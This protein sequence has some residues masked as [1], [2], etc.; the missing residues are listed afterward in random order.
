MPDFVPGF[1]SPTSMVIINGNVCIAF[2]VFFLEITL[3]PQ[4]PIRGTEASE[5]E[6]II[7]TH[8]AA[9]T[10]CSASYDS[11]EV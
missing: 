11:V 3:T 6:Q 1:A 9:P 7:G 5:I 4:F 2:K 10:S 8:K